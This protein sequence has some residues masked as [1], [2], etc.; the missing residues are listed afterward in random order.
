MKCIYIY[1]YIHIYIYIEGNLKPQ[2]RDLGHHHVTPEME[3][4]LSKPTDE[5]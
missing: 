4:E 5:Q 3:L 1:I 2:T